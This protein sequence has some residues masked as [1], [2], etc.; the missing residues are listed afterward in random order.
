M[1]AL[2]PPSPTTSGG[3]AARALWLGYWNAMRRYHRY[4]VE[5]L[6]HVERAG[7]ALIVGYHGRPV[8]HD[9]S[10]LMALLHERHGAMPHPVVH[11]AFDHNPVLRAVVE[12]MGGVTGDGDALRAALARGEKVIV[13]PGGTREGCRSV[14]HRYRVEWGGRLGY[15]RVALRHGLPI[16]PAAGAGVD[17]AF[18]GLN[19][20]E[21]LAKRVGVGVPLWLGVGPLGLWPLSPPFPVKIRTLVGPPIDPTAGGPIDPAD[22]G[23]LRALDARVRA[24]VQGL[25]DRGRR[26]T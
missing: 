25:L 12:G 5:G 1:T 16:I 26:R 3:R 17:D 21:A 24:A 2:A 20:G 8:A 9:L 15:L 11:A 19:D 18:V 14:R 6:A 7:P 22:R 4:E 13:T 10:M 23:S